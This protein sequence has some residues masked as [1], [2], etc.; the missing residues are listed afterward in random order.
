[1]GKII[2]ISGQ[3]F[4]RLNVISYAGLDKRNDAIWNC[5]CECGTNKVI[6]GRSLREGSTKSCGCFQMEIA[7]KQVRELLTTHGKS[8]SKIH[9]A[10]L[11]MRERCTNPNSKN[12]KNYGGRGISVCDSWLNSFESFFKDMGDIPSKEYSLDRIDNDKGYCKENCKWSTRIEQARNTRHNV[13]IEYNG[14]TQTISA[15]SEE[16]GIKF[17]TLNNRLNNWSI[18]KALTFPVDKRYVRRRKNNKCQ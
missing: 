5:V 3:N 1:M 6:A 16:L 8:G 18:E 14:K 12:Y 4:G 7:A 15:W 13:Y 11:A 2:D 17:T 10:W 9:K